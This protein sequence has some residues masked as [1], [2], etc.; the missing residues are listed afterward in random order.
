MTFEP[1]GAV[2]NR[3]QVVPTGAQRGAEEQ[4]RGDKSTQEDD[5]A[6]DA[7]AGRREPHRRE[8]HP[9]FEHG[10]C[11]DPVPPVAVRGD[12]VQ[13]NEQRDI[14][15]QAHVQCPLHERDPGKQSEDSRRL[16]STPHQR[17]DQQLDD[18]PHQPP[19]LLV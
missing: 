15:D 10:G 4:S 18:Q 2:F 12:R 14:R 17:D 16:P 6:E 5:G 19:A 7:V 3:G 1:S 9:D 13:R 11:R 8:D